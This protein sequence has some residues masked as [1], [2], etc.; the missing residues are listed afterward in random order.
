MIENLQIKTSEKLN[1]T[2]FIK[3]PVEI[4]K[5]LL[6]NDCELPYM[7]RMTGQE[8]EVFA[9]VLDFDGESG[10]V[11]MPEWMRLELTGDELEGVCTVENVSIP[12]GTLVKIQPQQPEFVKLEDVKG[13]LENAFSEYPVLTKETIISFVYNERTYDIKIEEVFPEGKAIR[14]VDTDLEVDISEPKGYKEWLRDSKK[15]DI[16]QYIVERKVKIYGGQGRTLGPTPT[17]T[18]TP[19]PKPTPKRSIVDEM[20]LAPEALRLPP[21]MIYFGYTTPQY[22]KKM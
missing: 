19:K 9:G 21:G 8:S 12:Q 22:K 11:L 16:S 15:I 7:F 3:L 20:S 17:P 1:N 2:S 13:I 5:E 4:L 14:T 10:E 18:P 6:D